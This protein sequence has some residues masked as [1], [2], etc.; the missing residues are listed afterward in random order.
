MLLGRSRILYVGPGTL[1]IAF[2]RVPRAPMAPHRLLGGCQSC[3]QALATLPTCMPR[4]WV[5]FRCSQTQELIVLGMF[6][7]QPLPPGLSALHIILWKFAIIAFAQADEKRAAFVPADI[8][9]T[10]L[11]RLRSRMLSHEEA[12]RR[13]VAANRSR[14][15]MS[16]SSVS[17]SQRA[18]SWCA[19]GLLRRRHLGN[20][21][22]RGR[23]LDC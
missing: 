4:G 7:G 18:I 8:W 21:L 19:T 15:I 23:L 3:S 9:K 10:A 22:Q 14:G 20:M 5:G 13:R 17:A 2:R 12:Q 16:T 11:R 6:G 1:R